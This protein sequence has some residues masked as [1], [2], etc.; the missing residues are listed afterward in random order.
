MKIKNIHQLKKCTAL[1]GS[2]ATGKSTVI[3]ML[4]QFGSHIIDTDTIAREIVA[5][6]KPVLSKIIDNFGKKF[7]NKNG[8]LNRKALRKEIIENEEK[9]ELLNKITHPPIMEEVIKQVM[10]YRA[11]DDIPVIIDVPLLFE[12]GWDRYFSK[13]ILVYAPEKIQIR[14]LMKR[15]SVDLE[16]A[17]ATV[18]AQMDIEKKRKRSTYIID[19]SGSLKETKDQTAKIFYSIY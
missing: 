8:T 6:S 1:T 14:R 10:Q 2:I 16:T 18:A 11:M 4:L 7:L 19:N 5:P 13:I 15:D 3:K 9:R 12:T 17:K